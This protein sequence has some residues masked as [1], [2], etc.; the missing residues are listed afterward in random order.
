MCQ[1]LSQEF[2]QPGDPTVIGDGYGFNGPPTSAIEGLITT[3][4]QGGKSGNAVFSMRLLLAASKANVFVD[5]ALAEQIQNKTLDATT[6]SCAII[7]M[8]KGTREL[9]SKGFLG[10][11]LTNI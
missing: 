11:N 4:P 7:S 6:M 1:D 9:H 5:G 10:L 2:G 3:R 8:V